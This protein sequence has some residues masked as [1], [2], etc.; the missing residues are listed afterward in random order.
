M[1][2]LGAESYITGEVRE[3]N[4]VKVILKLI[5]FALI[6]GFLTIAVG[7]AY[8]TIPA[9]GNKTLI[10]RTGSMEPTIGVGSMIVVRGGEDFY[11]QGDIIAFKSE[12]NPNTIITHRIDS[13]SKSGNSATYKTKGDAN[14]EVDAWQVKGE[15]VLGAVTY[16]IPQAGK[17]FNFVKSKNGFLVMIVAPAIFVIL[18]ETLNIIREIRKGRRRRILEDNPFGFINYPTTYP[19]TASKGM[20]G[21][22]GFK[23]LAAFIVA[24]SILI[25][26]TLALM[27]DSEVSAGN[28]FEASDDFD[29]PIDARSFSQPEGFILDS[30]GL[31]II[32]L[33]VSPSPGVSSEPSISPTPSPSPTLNS[34]ATPSK[35]F[36]DEL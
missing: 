34:S 23:M 1:A 30:E 4:L 19:Y 13:V 10:V 3:R 11:K 27:T 7:I 14:E 31:E 6:F 17:F 9:F 24:G 21:R 33:E 16:T 18:M 12:K 28:T 26:G 22:M 20:F 35:T 29:E 32:E 15:N 2:P 8:M 25:P 5:N 36:E